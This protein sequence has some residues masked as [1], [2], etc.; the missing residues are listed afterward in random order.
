MSTPRKDAL[1]AQELA[2][3]N[4][5]IEAVRAAGGQDFVAGEVNRTQSRISDYCS[6]SLRQF[7]PIDL[8]VV[9]DSLGTGKPG[10]PHIARAMV[11]ALGAT[12][13]AP[14]PDSDN[15]HLHEWLADLSGESADVIRALVDGAVP[16]GRATP[17]IRTMSPNSQANVLREIDQLVDL[18]CA[19]RARVETQGN[20]S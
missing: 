14:A 12:V 11:R 17:S 16:P 10:H 4:A 18:L 9:I 13:S 5:T 20:T 1:T 7:V 15:L 2:L 19:L 3:K 8:A 6:R